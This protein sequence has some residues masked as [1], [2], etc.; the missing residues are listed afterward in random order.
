MNAQPLP[1]DALIFYND[2]SYGIY[3]NIVYKLFPNSP[4]VD[5][6][7]SDALVPIVRS[8]SSKEKHNSLSRTAYRDLLS[9]AVEA[10][11]Y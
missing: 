1:I 5:T 6:E 4:D 8:S 11:R 3:N 7:S 2:A 10:L 9:K